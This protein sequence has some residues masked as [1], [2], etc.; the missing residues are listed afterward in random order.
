[1]S[2]AGVKK[3]YAA[4]GGEKFFRCGGWQAKKERKTGGVAQPEEGSKDT[5]QWLRSVIRVSV[6]HSRRF[7]KNGMATRGVRS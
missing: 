1:M 2:Y 6:T 4:V 7:K 3:S 5:P